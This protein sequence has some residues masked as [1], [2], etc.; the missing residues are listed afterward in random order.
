VNDQN[1]L[2]ATDIN[3]VQY[4]ALQD[5]IQQVGGTVQW[6]NESKQATVSSGSNTALVT[7]ADNNVTVDGR[8][9]ALSAPPLVKNDTLYVPVD[10]FA[11]VFGRQVY[12][13]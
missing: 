7:M 4:V 3:G 5:G 6:N 2:E 8:T 10:F 11:N 13:A 9:I 12:L 1:G